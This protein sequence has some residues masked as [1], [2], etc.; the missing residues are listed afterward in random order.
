MLCLI[1]APDWFLCRFP[2]LSLRHPVPSGLPRP[3]GESGFYLPHGSVRL[4]TFPPAGRPHP[5]RHPGR[6]A[7]SHSLQ[8]TEALW[9]WSRSGA[10]LLGPRPWTHEPGPAAPEPTTVP[11]GLATDCPVAGAGTEPAAAI[12]HQTNSAGSDGEEPTS[13]P[14]AAAGQL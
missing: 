12:P 8:S 2:S 3:S 1:V 6:E 13:P 10:R 9:S 4:W 11:A 7:V 14:R 5:G